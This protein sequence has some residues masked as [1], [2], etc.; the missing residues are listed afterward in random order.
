MMRQADVP[1]DD[2]VRQ[3]QRF[4]NGFAE[5]Y[6]AEANKTLTIQGSRILHAHMVL[7]TVTPHLR[8]HVFDSFRLLRLVSL[9][10][11]PF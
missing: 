5:V 10:S 9:A 7:D 2:S 3:I 4:W 6:T 1:M 8:Q 11:S